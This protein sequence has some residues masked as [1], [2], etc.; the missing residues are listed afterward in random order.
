MNIISSYDEN[1]YCECIHDADYI[2]DYDGVEDYYADYYGNIE[3]D[4]LMVEI[5]NCKKE[6]QKIIMNNKKNAL[7]NH[8][9]NF[10]E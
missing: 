5:V 9:K 4:D 1:D 3:N 7:L 6:S 8:I 10:L 2:N